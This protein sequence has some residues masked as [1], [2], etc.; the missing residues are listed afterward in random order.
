M[1]IF[2]AAVI[3]ILIN[4]WVSYFISDMVYKKL[5]QNK[6]RYAV[7]AEVLIFLLCFTILTILAIALVLSHIHF[8]R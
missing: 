2:L 1:I 8:G 6:V 7:V 3:G 5:K 4:T